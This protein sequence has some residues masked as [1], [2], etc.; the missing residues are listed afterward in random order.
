M[1]RKISLITT[2]SVFVLIHSLSSEE[3]QHTFLDPRDTFAIDLTNYFNNTLLLNNLNVK[4]NE[5]ELEVKN[6]FPSDLKPWIHDIKG[7]GSFIGIAALKEDIALFFQNDNR[8]TTYLIA[9]MNTNGIEFLT[10]ESSPKIA[11][12]ERICRAPVI[13]EESGHKIIRMI[14][15]D[16]IAKGLCLL[17]KD[18]MSETS[19][20]CFVLSGSEISEFEDLI[21]GNPTINLLEADNQI[22][23]VIYIGNLPKK[24]LS[25][26]FWIEE[27]NRAKLYRFNHDKFTIGKI[28]LGQYNFQNNTISLLISNIQG[29]TQQ[30][31]SASLK[32]RILLEDDMKE[33]MNG[34]ND[35][36][37]N[38]N[39]IIISKI[40]Y[41]KEALNVL[42]SFPDFSTREIIIE[43][44][45]SSKLVY[46]H[47][48]F[49]FVRFTQIS[50]NRKVLVL[51]L[52][53]NLQ[54]LINDKSRNEHEAFTVVNYMGYYQMFIF[55]HL[56]N[57]LLGCQ[58]MPFDILTVK[59]RL[60]STNRVSE[61]QL[62]VEGHFDVKYSFEFSDSNVFE[63]DSSDQYRGES[64]YLNYFVPKMRGPFTLSTS[65]S[66]TFAQ[67][68]LVSKVLFSNYR[69]E[70]EKCL[71]TKIIFSEKHIV[72]TCYHSGL[73]IF[74]EYTIRRQ[75]IIATEL[76]EV[77]A[78][79]TKID[80]MKIRDV[81]IIF[82]SLLVLLSNSNVIIAS[83]I[84]NLKLSKEFE[85]EFLIPIPEKDEVECHLTESGVVCLKDLT[86]FF[87][88]ELSS[89]KSRL[90]LSLIMSEAITKS[91]GKFFKSEFDKSKFMILSSETRNKQYQI[92][93]SDD[94]KSQVFIEKFNFEVS[95]KSEFYPLG[96]FNSIIIGDP[97]DHNSIYMIIDK[98]IIHVPFI[99]HSPDAETIIGVVSSVSSTTFAIMYSS[100][101]NIKVS[102]F[103]ATLDPARR[104]ISNTVAFSNKCLK[105]KGDIK[106]FG[107]NFLFLILSCEN[108]VGSISIWK[109]FPEG[110]IFLHSPSDITKTYQFNSKDYSIGFMAPPMK[111]KTSIKLRELEFPMTIYNNTIVE[112]DDTS[113]YVLGDVKRFKVV[114]NP[115]I[116]SLNRIRKVNSITLL[117]Q[118]TGLPLNL[119]I[120]YQYFNEEPIISFL[121]HQFRKSESMR[122]DF[123][124]CQPVTVM[125]SITE[126][127][128]YYI[129]QEKRSLETVLTNHKNFTMIFEDYILSSD[130]RIGESFLFEK[131]SES[132]CLVV[133]FKNTQTWK[134][135]SIFSPLT[136]ENPGVLFTR[137]F[138]IPEFILQGNTILNSYVSYNEEYNEAYVISLIRFTGKVVMKT[139]FIK[140]LTIQS[141]FDVFHIEK[142]E[143]N[144][145]YSSGFQPNE[146][147]DFKL[148][149][150]GRIFIYGIKFWREHNIWKMSNTEKMINKV[151]NSLSYPSLS[152]SEKYLAALHMSNVNDINLVIFK[153]NE[154]KSFVYQVFGAPELERTSYSIAAFNLHESKQRGAFL[155]V[156]YFS[157]LAPN[158]KFGS[159][160][161]V[162]VLLTNF[163]VEIQKNAKIGEIF[164]LSV[165]TFNDM[166]V[167]AKAPI[168]FVAPIK[169]SSLFASTLI[170]LII[171]SI[172]VAVSAYYGYKNVREFELI[173]AQRDR[174]APLE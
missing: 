89:M 17:K 31:F 1:K 93:I 167:E 148:F 78:T 4:Y 164:H 7:L 5:K 171:I 2:I 149:L 13:T 30:I 150:G 9:K 136:N 115:Q 20:S 121:N 90:R 152:V 128:P 144:T 44:V 92:L 71:P 100:S 74:S 111:S 137:T 107:S 12:K 114:G 48:N 110:P 53:K 94:N 122:F 15:A 66:Q 131:D 28:Q 19:S 156:T 57:S 106:T 143:E 73:L 138:S 126:K 132:F 82:G 112:I 173:A 162:T 113:M 72:A 18:M 26:L 86:N 117:S 123:K 70:I 32:N 108:P 21:L 40:N 8:E 27:N 155:E 85:A 119:D 64:D 134:V 97:Q 139:L 101:S 124:I 56:F 43:N 79:K 158:K 77:L 81:N 63:I 60:S 37:I 166:T 91:N 14:C 55:D 39:A 98:A 52:D 34:T 29:V 159:L 65:D 42:I 172:G 163:A 51:D 95:K 153:L 10:L 50:G 145:F 41:F 83:W 140:D 80:F 96:G 25:K 33:I 130:V 151:G 154:M 161:H 135:F 174:V 129:C 69:N 45:K 104:F 35:F 160:E 61:I 76:I 59:S 146:K 127:T 62:S 47:E 116:K 58:F 67:S 68:L 141:G 36:A 46:V 157:R 142:L 147:G 11:S 23:F 88:F 102:L 165:V 84:K 75:E 49:G 38:A 118:A 22:I 6:N 169:N 103:R 87:T 24:K 133:N 125:L 16:P 3:S 109:I 168:I 54:I 105:P 120:S 170:I 99:E